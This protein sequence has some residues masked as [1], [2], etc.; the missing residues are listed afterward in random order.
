MCDPAI[1]LIIS[2]AF[3]LLLVVA[4]GHKLRNRIRF[5]AILHAYQILPDAA[6]RSR[7][8]RIG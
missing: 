3:T 7:T 1:S 4:G 2:V 8:A 5:R 6:K